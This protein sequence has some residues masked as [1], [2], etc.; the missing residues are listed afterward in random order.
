MKTKPCGAFWKRIAS[1]LAWIGE[2]ASKWKRLRHLMTPKTDTFENAL[3][4]IAEN[5]SLRFL[6]DEN[7]DLKTHLRPH[8]SPIPLAARSPLYERLK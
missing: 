1:F 4:R 5:I 7:G 6:R 8:F 3:V 2:N